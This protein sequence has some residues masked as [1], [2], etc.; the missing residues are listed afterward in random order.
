MKT[1]YETPEQFAA[2]VAKHAR[3]AWVNGTFDVNG[4]AV[5]IKAHGTWVQR[6]NANC[7]TDSGEFRTQRD[8]RAFIVAHVG[9][10]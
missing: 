2:D 8:M 4:T 3:N 5:G 6:I 10:S 9:R 1:H 7:L